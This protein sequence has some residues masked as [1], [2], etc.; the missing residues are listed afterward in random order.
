M[1]KHVFPQ[2]LDPP[3]LDQQCKNGL[4]KYL[5][6]DPSASKLE[7]NLIQRKF[8]KVLN[9]LK[10]SLQRQ[11]EVAVTLIKICTATST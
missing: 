4:I 3:S 10:N 7:I 6:E 2:T 8:G 5:N 1:Y 9:Y 11:N